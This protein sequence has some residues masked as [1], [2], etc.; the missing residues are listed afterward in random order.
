MDKKHFLIHKMEENASHLVLQIHSQNNQML[1]NHQ[2]VLHQVLPL[3]D[4]VEKVPHKMMMTMIMKM[5]RETVQMKKFKILNVQ[6][7]NVMILQINQNLLE[8]WV[9]KFVF[10]V[11]K[12]VLKLIN[13][14][15]DHKFI[16]NKVQFVQQLFTMEKYKIKKVEKYQLCQLIHYKNIKAPMKTM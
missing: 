4:L 12:L 16:I 10:S 7:F 15:L 3:Q 6:I 14:F 5:K 9:E 8:K 1:Q 13:L 11:L 2:L